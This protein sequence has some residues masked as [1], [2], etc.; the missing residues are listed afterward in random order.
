MDVYGIENDLIRY[1]NERKDYVGP[2]L[3]AM[4]M[5][6]EI[7]QQELSEA[8]GYSVQTISRIENGKANP[9]GVAGRDIFEYLLKESGNN[10]NEIL[11]EFSIFCHNMQAE[12]EYDERIAQ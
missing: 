12:E 3:Q 6:Y 8:T 10:E 2:F 7:T 1:F 4:R 5:A 11:S 9:M